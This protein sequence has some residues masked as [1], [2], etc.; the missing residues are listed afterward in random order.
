MTWLVLFSILIG[1]VVLI[2]WLIALWW[3]L[4][5]GAEIRRRQARADAIRLEL[6]ALKTLTVEDRLWL[7]QQLEEKQ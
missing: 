2:G 7:S 5:L 4:T 3:Y 1:V 6:D